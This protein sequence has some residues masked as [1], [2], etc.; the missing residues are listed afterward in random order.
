MAEFLDDNES[1]YPGWWGSRFYDLSDTLGRS[2][3][4]GLGG[5]A[6]KGARGSSKLQSLARASAG[7]LKKVNAPAKAVASWFRSNYGGKK[8][9][10]GPRFKKVIESVGKGLGAGV[11]APVKG[12]SWLANKQ[13]PKQVIKALTP[14]SWV[15][16]GGKVA[17][18]TKKVLGSKGMAAN[19][20]LQG[21]LDGFS[22]VAGFIEAPGNDHYSDQFF[23]T[24]R[25][26]GNMGKR[27]LQGVARGAD[28]L[29]FNMGSGALGLFGEGGK[30]A[31]D[32]LTGGYDWTDTESDDG[33]RG[34]LISAARTPEEAA[35]VA[36]AFDD[37][38]LTNL[39]KG[40]SATGERLY[41]A[42]PR[43]G[44]LYA[45]SEKEG[46]RRAN[47]IVEARRRSQKMRQLSF[48]DDAGG[49]PS[50]FTGV[51]LVSMRNKLDEI[52]SNQNAEIERLNQEVFA[53]WDEDSIRREASSGSSPGA[54]RIAQRKLD[55]GRDRFVGLVQDNLDNKYERLR[56]QA[57]SSSAYA[58][59]S[60]HQFNE[61][62]S[63]IQR[64]YQ[65]YDPSALS[66]DPDAPSR[67]AMLNWAKMD[68]FDRES[69]SA[70]QVFHTLE[71]QFLAGRREELGDTNG[72]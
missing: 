51:D 20:A 71:G 1:E 58:K 45:L 64:F 30:K 29:V 11:A 47:V 19:F 70:E 60:D 62:V 50:A 36:K 65:S 56:D 24:G 66:K 46:T 14:D 41:D 4:L 35:A 22:S 49:P 23:R 43:T 5:L 40:L 54:R 28:S 48:L 21:V 32:I 25:M 2:A 16:S 18:G 15:A 33:G 44:K 31:A 72:K 59:F 9:L 53:S 8:V 17:S 69:I 57:R 39:S 3:A 34:E 37:Q 52:T 26:F 6:Y 61:L 38:E 42:D 63:G 55:L 12:A 10:N 27:V 68:T 67:E 7:G 13:I